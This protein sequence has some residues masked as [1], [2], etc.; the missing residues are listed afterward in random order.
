MSQTLETTRSLR[1]LNYT[2]ASPY[3]RAHGLGLGDARWTG[4][5]WADRFELTHRVIIPTMGEL[6]EGTERTHFL[7][8]FKIAAGLADGRHRG[9][10]WNDGDFFKWFEAVAAVYAIT[11]DPQLDA[12]M[13][14][15]IPIIAQAQAD[16]GYLHTPHLIA[17][18]NG[19]DLPRFAD[20]MHFE[21]YNMGHLMLAGCVHAR[22]TGKP[23]LLA[24][25]RRAADY[26]D[27]AFAH[28]TP[29]MARH[30]IC[31]VHLSGLIELYRETGE[32]RYRDLATRLLN[33]RDL[34]TN[35]DDDNQ[36]R[37]PFRQQR[38]A[39]GHAVRA[40]YLYTGAADVYAETGDESLMASLSP[41]WEDLVHR[42]LY[43]TGGCGA[44][45]DGASPDGSA[46][47]KSITRVHQAFGRPY[48][49]PHST[50]HNETCAA[51]GNLLWNWR[52][53]Q[54]SPE[55]RFGDVIELT[56]FNSVLAGVSLDG[57]RFFYTNTLRRLDPMPVELRWPQQRQEFLSCYCCPPNVAR[58]LAETPSYAS[59][60]TDD[61]LYVILYGTSRAQ[62]R[63]GEVDVELAQQT[64]YPWDGAIRIEV[65]TAAAAEWSLRLRIP[66]WAR[67]ARVSVNGIE[68]ASP[69]PGTYAE[70]K[71]VWKSGDIVELN[72]PMPVRRIEA[73]PYVEEARNHLAVMRGPLV[74][75]LESV[76]LPSD[77]R[78]ME[79]GMPR[80]AIFTVSR[81]DELGGIVTIH[82]TGVARPGGQWGQSLYR[83]V[84]RIPARPVPL[85]LIPYFAWDNRGRSEMSVWLPA[86]A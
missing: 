73:H 83:E 45:F 75:C 67:D 31:P 62:T 69:Q 39:V 51:I 11:R 4:G 21:M 8:N 25:A 59:A 20:P 13:D 23:S 5:F 35:G 16:D 52:M 42:K 61:G 32:T 81:T 15:I 79:V 49:L 60:R 84:P 44:L 43:I 68:T 36:D 86:V 72:L 53:H 33:M 24:I 38:Q 50:A 77:V 2:D 65:R 19:Q 7:Q 12:A 56:L 70:L 30:G 74:Y 66:A 85:K 41:I 1:S 48:Q 82:T 10:K 57:R 18:R 76:D 63:I 47:Q 78:L 27:R 29:Q 9:A 14:R 26:L 71:R 28:P 22:A 80:E 54:I 34:V 55:A 37:I 46:D 64:D 3:V 40:T 6:M 58:M 17:V